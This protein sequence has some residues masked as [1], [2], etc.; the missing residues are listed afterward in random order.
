MTYKEIFDANNEDLQDILDAVNDLPDA[1]SGGIT[2]SGIINITANGTYDVTEYA[3]AVVNVPSSG[4]PGAYE[5]CTLRLVNGG[6]DCYLYEVVCTTLNSDGTLRL[7]QWMQPQTEPFII[8]NVVVGLPCKIIVDA[9]AGDYNVTMT[10]AAAIEGT[11]GNVEYDESSM[12][13]F[14]V[15]TAPGEE[16]VIE[17]L[18]ADTPWD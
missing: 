18:A 6:G 17:Y 15:C 2:P 16:T 11:F 12:C 10:N 14:F 4:A 1:G 8:Q 13:R 7:Y 3:S 9:L 5:T